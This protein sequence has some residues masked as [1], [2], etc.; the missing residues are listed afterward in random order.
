MAGKPSY[1]RR[2]QYEESAADIGED[3]RG[4]GLLGISAG[5]YEQTARDKRE[6]ARGQARLDKSRPKV[7]GNPW[8]FRTGEPASGKAAGGGT[9]IRR[10]K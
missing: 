1:G 3:K 7:L 5:Q 4:A 6:D 9:P 10:R 2:P 8:A